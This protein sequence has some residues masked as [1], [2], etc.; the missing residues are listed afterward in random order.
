MAPILQMAVVKNQQQRVAGFFTRFNVMNSNEKDLHDFSTRLVGL[1]IEQG[2]SEV[3]GRQKRLAKQI[4]VS[5]QACS[6]WLTGTG[7]PS[8][9][10]V[11]KLARW[12]RVLPGWLAFGAGPKR[13]ED[14]YPDDI[15]AAIVTMYEVMD[16]AHR[17]ALY[18]VAK[19]LSVQGLRQQEPAI[20]RP[21]ITQ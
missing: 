5:Q 14:L 13:A 17:A 7:W 8:R 4:G 1:C 21:P 10:D 3:R 2:L 15:V 20:D 16:P 12:G 11:V 18:S 9:E 19:S 6:R